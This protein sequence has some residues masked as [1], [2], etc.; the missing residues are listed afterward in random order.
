MSERTQTEQE[1]AEALVEALNLDVDADAIEP[2]A[3]L[4]GDGLGLDS[5]DALEIAME[6][7]RRYGV[8]LRAD[9]A[10]NQQVFFSLRSLAK[11]V[12][13]HRTR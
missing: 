10:D 4:F 5:I 7:S 11:Y 12:D 8:Q 2:E 1:L 3:P 6:V 9:D 13:Q